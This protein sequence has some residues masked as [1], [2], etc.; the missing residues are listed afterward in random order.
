M[1]E[2]RLA[3]LDVESFSSESSCYL[4]ESEGQ[5]AD[6]VYSY[7]EVPEELVGWLKQSV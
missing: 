4:I 7:I 2:R 1:V 5:T 3:Q 6:R